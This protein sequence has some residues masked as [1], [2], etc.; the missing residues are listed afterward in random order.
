MK[1]H[2]LKWAVASGYAIMVALFAMI[3][4]KCAQMDYNDTLLWCELGSIAWLFAEVNID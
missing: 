1:N 2:S 4:S 3:L